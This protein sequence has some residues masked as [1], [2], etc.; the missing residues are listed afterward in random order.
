MVYIGVTCGGR[1]RATR[2]VS[3]SRDHRMIVKSGWEL[4]VRY[5]PMRTLADAFEWEY[6]AI[7]KA[8]SDGHILENRTGSAALMA[9]G[10]AFMAIHLPKTFERLEASRIRGEMSLPED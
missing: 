8:A 5:I 6:W 10:R 1:K 3:R 9:R 4:E 2:M 7:N